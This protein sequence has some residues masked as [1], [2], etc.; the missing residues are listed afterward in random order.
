MT[1]G[2]G[3]AKKATKKRSRKSAASVASPAPA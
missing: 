3:T 2:K 1:G